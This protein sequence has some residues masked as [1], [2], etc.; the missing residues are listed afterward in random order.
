MLSCDLDII[1]IQDARNWLEL[2]ALSNALG[3]NYDFISDRETGIFGKRHAIFYKK[4]RV[5]LI[6]KS[7]RLVLSKRDSLESVGK[8]ACVGRFMINGMVKS[9]E[10]A[11]MSLSRTSTH[12]AEKG[13]DIIATELDFSNR[14]VAGNLSMTDKMPEYKD[15]M[16]RLLVLTDCHK[17]GD[18]KNT[19]SNEVES[20]GARAEMI[21]ASNSIAKSLKMYSDPM[22]FS[23]VHKLVMALS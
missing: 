23:G 5:E 4:E 16:K 17:K 8:I 22:D 7:K 21:L 1:C 19:F 13:R 20:T 12:A 3:K 6:E 15:Y 10:I 2:K 14:I 9:V 11:S 18:R